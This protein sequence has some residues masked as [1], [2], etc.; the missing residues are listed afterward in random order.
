MEEE[1]QL[2]VLSHIW[3][4]VKKMISPRFRIGYRTIILILLTELPF[5]EEIPEDRILGAGY[6]NLFLCCAAG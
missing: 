5:L 3:D 1:E 2:A 6:G 4:I